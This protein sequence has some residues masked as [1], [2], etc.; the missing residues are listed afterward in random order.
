M[1]I[2]IRRYIYNTD[3]RNIIGD[4]FID[5][6]FIC[7]TLEDE[8]RAQGVKVKHETCIDAGIYPVVVDR[9]KRFRRL[10]PRLIGVPR[11][12]GIRIHGGND[13]DDT[14]GCP[15]VCYNSD[16]K[17]IWGTAE[18]EV[19]KLLLEAQKRDEEIFI[20]I[21]NEPLT[22]SGLLFTK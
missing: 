15:L 3:V 7:H 6:K 11:F 18:K 17:R 22:Y 8:I 9:S 19:T 13:E 1:R 4:M 20:E 12:S 10:M 14:S 5:G 2:Q 16:K 21:T